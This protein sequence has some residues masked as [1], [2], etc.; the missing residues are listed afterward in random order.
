MQEIN[1]KINQLMKYYGVKRQKELAEILNIAEQNISKWIRNNK[2]PEK[3]LEVLEDIKNIEKNEEYKKD[4]K[5]IE[6]EKTTKEE[7]A[8]I[9]INRETA[10]KSIKERVDNLSNLD[11]LKII[12]I[13]YKVK[14]Q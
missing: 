10:I 12:E 11:I 4:D 8:N 5:N 13:I 2:I 3:Y 9:M 14:I 1:Q 7:F 6:I